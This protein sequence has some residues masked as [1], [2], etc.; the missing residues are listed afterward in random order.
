MRKTISRF[1]SS[2]AALLS[3]QDTVLNVDGRLESIRAAMLDAL[4]ELERVQGS[5]IWSKVDGA[6][7]VQSLWYL[8]SELMALL[9]AHGGE[10]IARQKLDAITELFRGVVPN[11][12]MPLIHRFQR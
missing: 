9:A 2:F 8:R 11:N 4:M 6:G 10:R 5:D 12:Q 7:E 3:D 1:T